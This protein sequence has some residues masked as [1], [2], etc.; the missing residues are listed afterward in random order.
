MVGWQYCTKANV[1]HN[2]LCTKLRGGTVYDFF[3]ILLPKLI[4]STLLIVCFNIYGLNY[5]IDLKIIILIALILSVLNIVLPTKLPNYIGSG[6][7]SEPIRL[8]LYCIF[9]ILSSNIYPND[10]LLLYCYVLST[11]MFIPKKNTLIILNNY[12]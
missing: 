6:L 3:R 12:F 9:C 11:E 2:S 10:G 4:I 5:K 7:Y 1:F 8:M